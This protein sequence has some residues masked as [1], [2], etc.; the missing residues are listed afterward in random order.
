MQDFGGV[1]PRRP[2]TW[3]RR[4]LVEVATPPCDVAT[5][6]QADRVSRGDA[7]VK[8]AALVHFLCS[9]EHEECTGVPEG[10]EEGGEI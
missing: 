9:G 7:S 4:E 2:A 1:D 8:K 3:L 5:V 10:V 6:G